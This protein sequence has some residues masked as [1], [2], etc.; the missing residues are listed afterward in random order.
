MKTNKKMMTAIALA[1]ALGFFTLSAAPA[2]AWEL[3]AKKDKKTGSFKKGPTQ[4][5][6]KCNGSWVRV[7]SAETLALLEQMEEEKVRPSLLSFNIALDACA[8]G[9]QGDLAMDRMTRI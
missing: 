7:A 5:H 8:K 9:V 1:G 6:K 2:E 3:C 4:L